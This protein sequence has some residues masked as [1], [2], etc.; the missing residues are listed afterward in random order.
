LYSPRIVLILTTPLLD[1]S[2]NS[3]VYDL[4]LNLTL[5]SSLLNTTTIVYAPSILLEVKV[6]TLASTSVNY[7]PAVY[8]ISK[9]I[10]SGNIINYSLDSSNV[11][12]YNTNYYY[13]QYTP[14]ET[15]VRLI[16]TSS[17]I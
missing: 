9:Y 3:V 4:K 17:T 16:Q 12:S 5:T 8:S 11:V 6:A 7:A 1:N 15:F 13:V 10:T 2:S 14:N